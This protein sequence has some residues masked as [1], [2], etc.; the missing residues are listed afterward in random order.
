MFPYEDEAQ[1]LILSVFKFI[2]KNSSSKVNWFDY[3]KNNFK[4]WYFGS[5]NINQDKNVSYNTADHL[6][7]IHIALISWRITKDSKFIDWATNYAKEFANRLVLS[8]KDV[9]LAWD[10]NWQDYFSEDMLSKKE[11]YIISSHHHHPES[12]YKSYENLIA[13][14]V[15]FIFGEL[16]LHTKEE[17]FYKASK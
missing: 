11:K 3:D 15:I 1:N 10:L 6:R 16:Y 4:S 12:I 17:V 5:H 13:S 9:P 2:D 7:F 8:D 14:G